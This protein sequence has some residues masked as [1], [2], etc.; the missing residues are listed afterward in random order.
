MCGGRLPKIITKRFSN[1]IF[2]RVIIGGYITGY[3][4]VIAIKIFNFKM[5]TFLSGFHKDLKYT[6]AGHNLFKF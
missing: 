6:V 5:E 2:L 3:S 4:E 1:L